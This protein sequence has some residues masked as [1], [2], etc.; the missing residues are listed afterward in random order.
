M[1]CGACKEAHETV[2]EVR[3]CHDWKWFYETHGETVEQARK[4]STV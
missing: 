4:W 1:I 2:A 3:L